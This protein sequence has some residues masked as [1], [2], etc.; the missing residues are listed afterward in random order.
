MIAVNIDKGLWCGVTA[1]CDIKNW[2]FKTLDKITFLFDSKLFS[3]VV[4][5][6]SSHIDVP[7]V[8]Q[9][10]LSIAAHTGT[11]ARP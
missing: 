9:Q 3:I 1:L 8:A 5:D 4:C 11:K 2:S 6:F 10:S 7:H